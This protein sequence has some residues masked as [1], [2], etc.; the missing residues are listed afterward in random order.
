M[1]NHSEKEHYPLNIATSSD[2]GKS[3]EMKLTLEDS[4][5]EYS[6]PCV[7]QS[8]D[9]KVHVSYTW[10]RKNIKYVV[11]DPSCF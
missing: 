8:D 5:G 3:W 7:I 9:G 2:N 11:L 4:P 6:Y 1:Y 10:N